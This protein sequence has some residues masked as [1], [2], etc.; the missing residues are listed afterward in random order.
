MALQRDFAA[1][2]TESSEV[3][4]VLD[5][6]PGDRARPYGIPAVLVFKEIEFAVDGISAEGW[7]AWH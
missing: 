7:Q 5:T 3:Y 4:H 6:N 1:S 2:V